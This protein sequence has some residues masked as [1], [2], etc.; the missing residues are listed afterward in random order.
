MI[1]MLVIA[2]RQAALSGVKVIVN[3][4]STVAPTAG[5]SVGGVKPNLPPVETPTGAKS[6][7]FKYGAPA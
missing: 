4:A 7:P 2:A 5:V 3:G 1:V 6:M